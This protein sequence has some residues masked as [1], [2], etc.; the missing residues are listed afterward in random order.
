MEGSWVPE[1]L[2]ERL[3]TKNPLRGGLH[4]QEVNLYCVKPLRFG[5]IF[6]L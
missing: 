2:C 3:E 4:E 5:D 6:L 1:S